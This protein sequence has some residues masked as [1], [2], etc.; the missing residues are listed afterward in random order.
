MPAD[1]KP[2]IV[3]QFRHLITSN[4]AFGADWTA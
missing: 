4:S 2:D 3:G 1:V